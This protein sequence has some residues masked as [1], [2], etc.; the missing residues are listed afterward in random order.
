MPMLAGTEWHGAV[1]NGLAD[2]GGEAPMGAH[3]S[4]QAQSASQQ[5]DSMV[6]SV[7]ASGT[8]KFPN[9]SKPC[10]LLYAT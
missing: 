4:K 1:A 3:H 10:V 8:C 7:R 2:G 6:G 9:K 5:C